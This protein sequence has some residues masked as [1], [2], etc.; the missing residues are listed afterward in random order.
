[1]SVEAAGQLNHHMEFYFKQIIQSTSSLIRNEQIQRYL[2]NSTEADT[3]DIELELI[4]NM[5]NNYPEIIGMF[6]M[7]RDGDIVSAFGKYYNGKKY[8]LEEPWYNFRF[9]PKFRFLR[10]TGSITLNIPTIRH[11]P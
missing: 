11:Y 5:G 6:I 7:S 4:K 9:L 1:M 8:Y 3:Q 10:H 2:S